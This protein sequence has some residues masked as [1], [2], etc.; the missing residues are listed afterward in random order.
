MQTE[1]AYHHLSCKFESHRWLG[2]LAKTLCDKFVS[3]FLCIPVSSTNKTDCHG[4]TEIIFTIALPV[5][6]Y[7]S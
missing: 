5:N 2:V 4:I 1:R 6:T 7:S 3:E